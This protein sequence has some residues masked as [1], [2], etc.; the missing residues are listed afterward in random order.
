MPL[1]TLVRTVK[2]LL[3]NGLDAS[4]PEAPVTLQCLQDETFVYF[5]ITDQGAGMDMATRQRAAEPFFTTKEEGK[6]LGLGLFLAQNFARQFGGGLTVASEMAA[7]TT[8]T[9]S[10]ALDLVR[11]G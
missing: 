4:P 8:V 9:I 10:L 2:G 1:K 3:K 6:G 5:R 11:P 7:G